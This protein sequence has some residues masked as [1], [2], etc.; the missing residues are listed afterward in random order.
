MNVYLRCKDLE[1]KKLR[2]LAQLFSFRLST[3]APARLGPICPTQANPVERLWKVDSRTV[4]F[5]EKNDSGE[6][7][8]NVFSKKSGK[9]FAH[10]EKKRIWANHSEQAAYIIT[11]NFYYD[12]YENYAS[13][14]RWRSDITRAII[15]GVT[16]PMAGPEIMFYLHYGP[17]VIDMDNSVDKGVFW[18]VMNK[19]GRLVEYG[20]WAKIYCECG[21][22]HY[23]N[24]APWSPCGNAKWGFLVI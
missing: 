8:Y 22:S 10:F 21:R 12:R 13:N 16:K 19:M 1:P 9:P 24:D 3:K 23:R 11:L 15:Q 14:E 7:R 2:E 17:G 4:R 6:P 5:V 18:D 20:L